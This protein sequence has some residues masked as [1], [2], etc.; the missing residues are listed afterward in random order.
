M[1]LGIAITN[2]NQNEIVKKTIDI[3]SK[4]TI[5][6]AAI[7]VCS[8]DKQFKSKQKNVVCI[9]NKKLKG[10]CQNRN[11][12]IP[13]FLNADIDALIFIDGDCTI[14][15]DKFLNKYQQLFKK[16]DLIF[17]SRIHS[18]ISGLEKPPSDLLTANMD[19]LYNKTELD[20]RDL[21]VVSGAFDVWEKSKEFSEKLDLLL[22]G[23]ISWSCNFGITKKGLRK[24]LKFEEYNF[25]N[26]GLFDNYCFKGKWGYEDVAMGIDALYAGLNIGV[27]DEIHVLHKSHNRSD[28]LFDH[29]KG[30]HLIMERYRNIETNK[31]IKNLVYWAMILASLFY[32]AGL[33]TGLFTEYMSLMKIFGF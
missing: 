1:K 23:M 22:T 6:P 21:R 12:V 15:N 25:N 31:N 4:Q 24:L 27:S 13:Y 18:D 33:I 28:G 30:R 26:S 16:Y 2:H 19:N 14:M 11:S 32:F 9:N 3:I 17:G 8:D 5:R 29:I 10:R 20:Y 7:F